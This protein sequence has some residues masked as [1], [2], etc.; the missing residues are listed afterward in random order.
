MVAE[1]KNKLPQIA[2]LCKKYQMAKLWLFGSALEPDRFGPDS[3]VDFL[4]VEDDGGS[5]N[6]DYDYVANWSDLLDELRILLEREVQLITYYSIR[7]PYFKASVDAT[8]KLIYDKDT[9]KLPA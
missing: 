4:Y 8:K 1:V 9:E 6:P 3:D 2:A 7:N 5:Y